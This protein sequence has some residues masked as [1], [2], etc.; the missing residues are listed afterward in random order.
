MG[1]DLLALVGGSKLHGFFLP[2]VRCRAKRF[3]VV[4]GSAGPVAEDAGPVQTV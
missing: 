1:N 2:P 4:A 3:L